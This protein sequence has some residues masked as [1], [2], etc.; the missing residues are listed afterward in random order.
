MKF[1]PRSKIFADNTESRTFLVDGIVAMILGITVINDGIGE[2]WNIPTPLIQ[3]RG[4]AV[5]REARKLREAAI[6]KFGLRQ[7]RATINSSCPDDIKWIEFLG[8][9]HEA[10]LFE[11]TPE[12]DD[13]LIYKYERVV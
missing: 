7:I 13:L 11:A 6:N 8:F 3:G 4:L 1:D 12:L 5:V 10:T 9:K 2:T